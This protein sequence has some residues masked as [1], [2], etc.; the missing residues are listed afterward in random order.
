MKHLPLAALLALSQPAYA[1]TAQQVYT[2]LVITYDGELR[3]LNGSLV[4]TEYGACVAY[5]NTLRDDPEH[6]P[7]VMAKCTRFVVTG[8]QVALYEKEPK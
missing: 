3:G 2:A 4:F 8:G 7:Y 6:Q 5:M 1:D